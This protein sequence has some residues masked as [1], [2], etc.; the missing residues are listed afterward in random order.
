M[1]PSLIL[2]QDINEDRLARSTDHNGLAGLPEA[3]KWTLF[4][5]DV[6]EFFYSQVWSPK[7]L[8]KISEGF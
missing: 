3:L 6:M 2:V 8:L 4:D 1:L 5:S 7:S